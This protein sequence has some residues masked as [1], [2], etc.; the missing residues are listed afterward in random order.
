[1]KIIDSK[2]VKEL[3]K[4]KKLTQLQLAIEIGKSAH[5]IFRLESGDYKQTKFLHDIT[6][7]LGCTED[8]ITKNA[9]YVAPK[10][11]ADYVH[12]KSRLKVETKGNY[13]CPDYTKNRIVKKELHKG[14]VR[15]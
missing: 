4:K 8:D 12:V 13:F 6:K 3:R 1:M 7:V 11:R 14:E 15:V 9:D 10:D 5:L 2:K